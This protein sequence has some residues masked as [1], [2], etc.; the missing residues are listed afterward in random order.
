MGGYYYLMAQLPALS[1]NAPPGISRQEFLRLAERFLSPPDWSLLCSLS[2]VPPAGEAR[3]GS[4][5]ADGW[6]AAERALRLALARVRA[7]KLGRE[8][9][10][11]SAGWDPQEAAEILA[12]SPDAS[13][14][15]RTAA[16]MDN[17]LEAEQYLDKIRF[18][19]VREL[20]SGHFFDSEAVFAYA[21][22]LMIQERSGSFS[23]ESG[24]SGYMEIYHSI[25]SAGNSGG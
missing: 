15:A 1:E 24:R 7:G 17:P 23:A 8:P 20:G 16:S 12:A 14:V 11:A 5:V 21:L 13:A 10:A 2:L 4:A 25:L 6:Y 9:A 19:C 3:T 18:S 22:M